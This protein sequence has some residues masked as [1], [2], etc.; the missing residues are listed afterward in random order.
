VAEVLERF[1][2]DAPAL[3]DTDGDGIFTIPELVVLLRA[4]RSATLST[5][6]DPRMRRL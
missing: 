1:Y 2:C 4:A 6:A 3:A 5:W